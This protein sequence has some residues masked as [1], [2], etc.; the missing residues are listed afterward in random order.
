VGGYVC[1]RIVGHSE[2]KWASV[3]AAISVTIGFVLSMQTCPIA[4][5]VLLAVLGVACVML[6]GYVGARRNAAKA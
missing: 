4:L 6:G 1:A 3:V 5:N 2:L